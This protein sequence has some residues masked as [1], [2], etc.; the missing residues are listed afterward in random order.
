[1]ERLAFDAA[2]AGGEAALQM[3]AGI[4]D[5]NDRAAFLRG[6]FAR[7]AS[8]APSDAFR[9]VH[10][11]PHEP[12]R[13]TAMA[14]LVAQWR[15]KQVPLAV[16]ATLTQRYGAI[17]GLIARLGDEPHLAAEAARELLRGM[18]RGR[19]LGAAAGLLAARDPQQAVSFGSGLEGSERTEFMQHFAEGWARSA[20]EA[21]FA[22]SRQEPDAAVR[23]SLQAT[24]VATWA[25]HDPKA[26]AAY[27]P[28]ITG[29]DARGKVITALA[30]SWGMA[31]TQAAF[32]W[33]NSLTNGQERDS[34]TAGI[35]EA[36]PVGIGVVLGK[37]PEG[38][39]VIQEL[40]PGSTASLG[41]QLKS[42]YQIAAIGDGTGRF[43]E[44]HGKELSEV[45]PL[46]RGKPG[47]TVSL[48]VIPAGASPASRITVVIPR[49]QLML[50]R[51][52]G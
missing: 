9:A 19:V 22:W 12:D 34:A 23:D 26:A 47:S 29:A 38:Y 24:I 8:G 18:E 20:G 16:Q 50:N 1:M 30:S 14:A 51:P 36:A 28:S 48:Q 37:S 17:G 42:G 33:A 43:I 7:L 32:A 10:S 13:E 25:A 31:D 3:L 6:M 5:A 11:L 49:Q 40:I 2:D 15:P 4:T 27:L 39:P 46:I 45:T 52:P 21:A 44:V 41:G 35:R